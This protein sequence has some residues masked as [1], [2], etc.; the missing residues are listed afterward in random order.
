MIDESLIKSNFIGRDGFRWW[1]GQIPP[2]ESWDNQTNGSGWGN[3]YKV[4]IIGYHPYNESELPNEDLPWAG[5]L[6]PSTAGTGAASYAQ[7]PKLRPGDVV[8][9]FF[10][11]GDNAQIPMIMGAFGRT[12]QVPSTEYF[13]PFVPFTG[14]TNNIKKPDGKTLVVNESSEVNSRTDGQKSPRDLSP[15]QIAQLNSKKETKDETSYYS[16]IGQKVVPAD[17]CEDSTIN[18]ITGILENFLNLVNEGA[19]F[20]G[21]VMS[22]ASSIQGLAN[23]LVG[24]MFNS[25]FNELIPI[26]QQGL[27]AFYELIFA[28]VLAATGNPI[29]AH[30]AGVAAQESMVQPVKTLEDTISCVASQIVNGLGDMIKD[31]IDATVLQITNFG[32][33]TAEQFVSSL[34]NSII[35]DTLV[36]LQSA[37]DG[38]NAI[39]LATFSVSDF[40]R[41]SINT[42][43]SIGGLFDC[44]QS[45]GKCNGLVKNWTIGYGAE[46]SFDLQKTYENVLENMNISAAISGVTTSTSPYTR[47]DC[48]V[49]T[50]CGSPIVTFFGGSGSGVVGTPLLGYLSPEIQNVVDSTINTIQTASIIGV[51]IDNPGS[52]YQTAPP[53]VSFS[54]SCNLGYGAIGQAIVDYDETSETYGQVTGVNIISTGENYPA[55][56]IDVQSGSQIADDIPSTNPYGVIDTFVASPGSD[57]SPGDNAIDDIGNTYSLTISNGKIISATPSI[58]TITTSILPTITINSSTGSG[59]VIKPIIG[60]LSKTPQGEIKQ[61]IDCVE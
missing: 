60:K 42:I 7:N 52:G 44:N 24:Q 40:L 4:R 21:D 29:A 31:L 39:L 46:G 2:V 43:K 22:V 12:N 48:G 41:S 14:Y 36:G 33:C 30:A 54:D 26:L 13:S 6:L 19:D 23:N 45:S 32:L 25:L 38:V 8:V 28:Q 37:L 5:V 17:T 51:Q 49:P 53:L 34:V 11:D 57:Y 1:I 10:L 18:Q 56:A 15:E 47:P 59:A 55:G 16:G 3:R 50:V 58:N 20:L 35:D 27:Q 9:G 61:V